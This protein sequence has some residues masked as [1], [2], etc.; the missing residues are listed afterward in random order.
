MMYGDDLYTYITIQ[1]YNPSFDFEAPATEIVEFKPVQDNI[2]I[3]KTKFKGALHR[4]Q[5]RGFVVFNNGDWGEAYNDTTGAHP[6]YPAMVPAE[7]YKMTYKSNDTSIV[8][9]TNKGVLSPVS[10]GTT[11][12]TV[13]ITGGLSFDVTVTVV[14]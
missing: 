5:I 13:T 12:V 3:H 1:V 10:V 7:Q 4:A 8:R 6:D 9:V 11:T 14:E 2:I